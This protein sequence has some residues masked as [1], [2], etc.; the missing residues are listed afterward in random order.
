MP[1]C[2]R[3]GHTE[4]K[5]GACVECRRRRQREYQADMRSARRKLRA[6]ESLVAG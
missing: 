2:T 5:H 6:I 3:P 4:F 1:K